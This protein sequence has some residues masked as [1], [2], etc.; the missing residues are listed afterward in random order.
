MVLL[1]AGLAG[2]LVVGAHTK[3]SGEIAQA[4]RPW[5]DVPVAIGDLDGDAPYAPEVLNRGL[6][7]LGRDDRL[8]EVMHQAGPP[9]GVE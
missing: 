9:S 3:E 8:S 2:A 5:P 1:T 4:K 6:T 7:A